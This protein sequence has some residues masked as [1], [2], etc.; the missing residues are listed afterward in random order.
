MILGLTGSIGMGKSTTA[1]MFAEE[2]VPVWDADAVVHR[3]YAPG[4]SAVPALGAL[5]PSVI[6][7]GRVDRGALRAI[8]AADPSVLDRID[9]VVHP[10]V[11]E[12]RA[13][14]LAAHDG[15]VVL[16]VPL[17]F[18]TGGD[19]ACDAVA[20]VSTDE[21]T[22][23]RRVLERGTMTEGELDAILSRQVPDAEKRRRADY[24]IPTDSMEGARSEVR[25]IVRELGHA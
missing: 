3:L 13:D 14:F 20:V 19:A 25:R 16:D 22:Q 24:V 18:E 15:L 17:L 2:G 12:D 23:R 1:A 8:V 9:A 7:E 5:F 10:M 4:G 11:A 6:R 21:A